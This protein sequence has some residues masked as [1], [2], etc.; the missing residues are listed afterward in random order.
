MLL[1]E[2]LRCEYKR[3]PVGI[4]V[5]RP[6]LDWK[7]KSPRRKVMQ[8]AYRIQA[9]L[10]ETTFQGPAD[11]VWDSGKQETDQSIQIEYAGPALASRRRY[12]WRVKVWDNGGEESAWSEVGFW[13][14]GLLAAQD[15]KAG[16][17]RPELEEDPEQSEP[18]PLLRK[19]F[20]LPKAI[21]RARLYVTA[22]GLYEAWINGRRVGDELF[23][24]G[25]TNYR[26]C[27]QYQTY[28]VTAMLQPGAN[29]LGVML[30]D[31]WYRGFISYVYERN[32]YGDQLGLYAQLEV[33]YADGSTETIVSD[34][35]WTA[36]T[37]PVLE[38]DLFNGEVYDARLVKPG[39]A[40]PDYAGKGWKPVRAVAFD[41]SVLKAPIGVPVRKIEEIKPKQILRTPAGETVADFGQ[42][43]TGWVRLRARGPAGT[44]ITLRHGE[45]LDQRGNFYNKNLRLAKARDIYLLNGS[46]EELFEPHFTFHGFRYVK[47]EGYPGHLSADDVTAVVIHSD[48]APAGEFSCSHPGLNRLFENIRW[49]QKGN[50]LDVPTDCPQRDERMG[51]T[52]DI[53]AYG[54]TACQVMD[55]APFLSRWLRDLAVDQRQSG[56][57]PMVIPDAFSDRKDFF[58]RILKHRT[59]R[60]GD[61]TKLTDKLAAVFLLNYSI[62]WGE[63]AIFIPWT[64]YLYYG[65]QRILETQ[66]ASMQSF[67]RYREKQA[68]KFGSLLFVS[69]RQWFQARTWKYLPE[70]YTSGWHFGDWLAPG[71]GMEKSILKSKLY[72]PTVF[73]ALDARILSRT[74]A[75]LGRPAEAAE[76]QE[77]Y[78]KIKQAFQHFLVKPDGRI[79]SDAQTA[80][81]LALLADLLPEASKAA[82]AKRLAEK[83]REAGNRIGT[84]FLGTPHICRVLSEHGYTDVAYDLL[85]QEV[86]PSWLYQV[87]KGATTIWEHWDAIK[88]DGSFQPERMLSFNHYA[89]GSIGAWLIQTVAGIG[90]D[91]S[92][93]GY[94]HIVIKPQPG[95]GLTFVKA[96]YASIHGLILSEWKLSE[97]LFR[98][99]VAI[100]ANTRATVFIPK[101][102]AARVTESNQ[103]VALQEGAIEIGSGQYE[104]DC[105]G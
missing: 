37:G 10:G 46:G 86:P 49:S 34:E 88:P 1:I 24:P 92:Q 72:L 76:Y 26:Q 84:G 7:L 51:W 75:V 14:M 33:A 64:L 82:A 28:D 79:R 60:E 12:F 97:N 40:E 100:P 5:R 19:E 11:L 104:F 31:G 80:Y 78:L 45:V 48:L 85:L 94:K 36:S 71:D 20:K 39:W 87:K 42:N 27:L 54:P 16:M 22:H 47:V 73:Y 53:L 9:A 15:W 99:R 58:N 56:A 83:V 13:E 102:Y 77:K 25:W 57:V 69:P 21:S 32:V 67:F 63:A 17:I 103:A 65:D 91:E 98:L 38:S 89:Y 74:A 50:F 3:N 93:P 30:G 43:L 8:T 96:S 95:G 59:K 62:G 105:S 29:A 23:A 70:F 90:P 41:P 66:Y 81:V 6:R 101:P 35:T 4:A 55:C 44:E 2:E 61:Y 18:C 68:R 52:G